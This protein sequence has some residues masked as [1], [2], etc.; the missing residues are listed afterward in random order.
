[1][2]K[3]EILQ[4][5]SSK[6]M[7]YQCSGQ[8]PTMTLPGNGAASKPGPHNVRRSIHKLTGLALKRM[9][10][11]FCSHFQTPLSKFSRKGGKK[12]KEGISGE[13]ESLVSH[14]S[15]HLHQAPRK[16]FERLETLFG[17]A[18]EDVRPCQHRR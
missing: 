15:L 10:H 18:E 2:T 9:E 8:K 17:V 4:K 11:L 6:K 1:M 7:D 14:G 3:K 12:K 5:S 16:P 13:L